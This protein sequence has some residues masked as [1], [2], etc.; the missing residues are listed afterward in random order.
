[1]V[2]KGIF[3]AYISHSA[4]GKV[5]GWLTNRKFQSPLVLFILF[6]KH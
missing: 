5:I 1:M 2:V 6:I 3:N 4:R